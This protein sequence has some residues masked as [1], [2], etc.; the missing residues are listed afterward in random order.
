MPHN[1]FELQMRNPI[2]KYQALVLPAYLLVWLL[3]GLLFLSQEFRIESA[4]KLLFAI[5]FLSA[6]HLAFKDFL[7]SVYFSLFFFFLLPFDLFFFSIYREPPGTP[8]LLSIGDSNMAEAADFMRGRGMVLLGAF[9]LAIGVWLLTVKAAQ[10]GSGRNW[11]CYNMTS[12]RRARA[13]LSV[14]G[15]SWLLLATAPVIERS[16]IDA[17]HHGIATVMATIDQTAGA[18][19]AKLRPI[20]PVG[21]LVSLGEYYRENAY[22]R[23]VDKSKEK[24]RYNAQQSD[25]PAARQIYVFVIGETARAD[26]FPLNGYTR[27]QSSFLTSMENVIPLSNIVSPWTYTK[28]AVPAMLTPALPGSNVRRNHAKS[29]VSAFREAGFKSYW[30]SNQQP[31]RETEIWQ[32][33]READE[34]VFLNLSMR[35]MRQ[36]GLYDENLLAPLR[37]FLSRKEAKQFFVLHMLGAHDAYEKRYPRE[38]DLFKPSLLSLSNPDH[39]DRRNKREVVNSYDNAMR[40]TDFVLAKLIEALKKENAVTTVIYSSDHGETL[41]DGECHRSGH[42]SAGKQE[43]P[44]AAMVW[45]SN[46][47]K[48]QWPDKFMQLSAHASEPITAEY[49]LPTALDLAAIETDQLDQ[50]RSLANPAFK[51]QTRWVNAPGPLDWDAATTKG[52]CTILVAK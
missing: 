30:I 44:I 36:D 3:P 10:Q 33:A 26:H 19:L 39:H 37:N 50:S 18:P 38:F 5:I 42:G 7:R 41:F 6:W 28:F 12:R 14:L 20:F 32:F 27:G 15:V 1:R 48:Q 21:R 2:A 40:Y 49:I 47:Y 9:V 45:V 8:V 13:F 25:V 11:K 46:E 16:L 43:F 31:V 29:L 34:A 17:G 52:A 24:Y 35:V 22:L 4:T 23:Y 51:V